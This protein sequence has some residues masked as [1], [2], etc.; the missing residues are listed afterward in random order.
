MDLARIIYRRL[1]AAYRGGRRIFLGEGVVNRGGRG[2][3]NLIDVGAAGDLPRPWY[4]HADKIAN[5]LKFEPREQSDQRP[6]VVSVDAALWKATETR[7]FY[8]YGERGHGSS[9]FE[10]NYDYVR[11]NFGTLRKRGASHLAET[12]FSRSQLQKTVRVQCRTLDDVLAELDHPFAYH[13]LKLDVQGAEYEVLQGADA[14]LRGS[15]VA[16]HLE[17][18]TLPLYRGAVLLPDVADYLKTFD[19]D[20]VKRFPPHGSFDSQHDCLFIKTRQDDAITRTICRVYG[21]EGA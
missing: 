11:E 17:L 8:I 18:F 5:L 20:L 13:L 9:L 6:Y 10:Q 3:V 19:F 7:D 4:K 1:R 14:F 15:C 21:L 12:W 16:L 2:V